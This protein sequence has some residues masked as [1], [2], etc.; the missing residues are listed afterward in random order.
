MAHPIIADLDIVDPWE[1]LSDTYVTDG[2]RRLRILSLPDRARG[3]KTAVL[4]DCRTLELRLC[5]RRQLRRLR[6]LRKPRIPPG[7]RVVAR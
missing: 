3:L 5:G 2:R 6:K 1:E 7:E 4:E